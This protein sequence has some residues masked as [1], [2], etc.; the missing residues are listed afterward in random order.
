MMETT[1]TIRQ[2]RTITKTQQPLGISY[3]FRSVVKEYELRKPQN[4]SIMNIAREHDVQHRRVYDFFNMLTSLGVCRVIERGRLAWVGLHEIENTLMKTYAHMEMTSLCEC[5]AS[6][7]NAGTSPSLGT[8]ALN[9]IGLYFFL[10]VEILSMRQ[11]AKIFYDHQSDIKSLERRLY[12]VLN[13][14]EVINV[15]AHTSKTS[16]YRLVI[17]RERIVQYGLLARKNAC[18]KLMVISVES[19]LN[20]V[21]S[22]YLSGIYIARQ[23]EFQIL[24]CK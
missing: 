9:F 4:I 1:L 5:Q 17:N 10:G 14:L 22:I 15:V 6:L 11:A 2:R 20:R 19:L 24:S 8:L 16:Q 12:L 7:F 18:Q 21:D 23:E 3:V 13:F